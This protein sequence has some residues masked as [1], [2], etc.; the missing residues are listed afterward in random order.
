MKS[1]GGKPK[2]GLTKRVQ[3]KQKQGGVCVQC[4]AGAAHKWYTRPL[5]LLC[6]EKDTIKLP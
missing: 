3:A 2:G 1:G 6:Y 4:G 5:C